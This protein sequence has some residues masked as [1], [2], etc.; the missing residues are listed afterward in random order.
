[1]V[2]VRVSLGIRHQCNILKKSLRRV[3][4][5]TSTLVRTIGLDP[6]E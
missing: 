1:M 2:R 3:C 6:T 4:V 5:C